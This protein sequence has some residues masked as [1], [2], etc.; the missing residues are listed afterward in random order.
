VTDDDM[1]G[2][3]CKIGSGGWLERIPNGLQTEVG[4]RGEHD[5]TFHNTRFRHQSLAFMEQV[6]EI[7]EKQR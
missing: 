1:M 4:E 7:I 5:L 2:I 3:A 6:Q